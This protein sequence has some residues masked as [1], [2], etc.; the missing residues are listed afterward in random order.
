MS[1][2]VF[3]IKSASFQL[4]DSYIPSAVAVDISS[5]NTIFEDLK[6]GP[7]LV[8]CPDEVKM[9]FDFM[10]AVNSTSHDCTVLYFRSKVDA[11]KFQPYIFSLLE[12]ERKVGA[13]AYL[14]KGSTLY[15][16]SY[17]NANS[18]GSKTDPVFNLAKTN[19]TPELAVD[20][21]ASLQSLLF[22]GVQNLP[23]AGENG[24]GEK[25][26]L[27]AGIDA[28]GFVL[29]IS[30]DLPKE[31]LAS[32][33]TNAVL[34]MPR[35]SADFFEIRYI[36]AGSRLEI[37]CL[38]FKTNSPEW[39]I[40][41]QTNS[42]A[43]AI[44]SNKDASEYSYKSIQSIQTSTPQEKRVIKGGFK[45]KFSDTVTKISAD[46]KQ[47][48]NEVT[49][50]KSNEENNDFLQ[51]VVFGNEDAMKEKAEP[52]VPTSSANT[53]SDALL[54]SKI[55]S[56]ESTL[57]QREELINKLNKEIEEI[58]DPMKMGVISGIKDNQLQGFKDNIKRLEQEI[59]TYQ[60]KEKELMG[61]VDKAINIKD[62][63]VKK[64]KELETKLRQSS[65]GTNSKVVQ[66]EKQL[67]EQKRQNKEISKR[68][69]QLMEQTGTK[70]A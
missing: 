5:I 25:I 39:T 66:L 64:V 51:A 8:I 57:K 30:F 14:E 35:T 32:L 13:K 53:K 70:A 20:V 61:L 2:K 33:K 36:E 24:T 19:L 7:S 4:Q 17:F 65:G 67:D 15:S 6:N 44:D 18:L 3:L 68:L 9:K 69:N 38:F 63:S 54:T 37:V 27:Q 48:D 22:L 42:K 50:V 41:A 10:E 59:A 16:E 49:V 40:E 58:K 21:W 11:D 26:D 1:K 55:E 31:K 34:A 28:K 46:P 62:E 45:K 60:E 47:T 56:L 12:N 52:V 23:S 29:S 43:V